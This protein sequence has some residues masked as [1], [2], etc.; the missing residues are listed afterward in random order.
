MGT[1]YTRKR[2][3]FINW[4][5][6]NNALIP[7]DSDLGELINSDRTILGM[8]FNHIINDNLSISIIPSV[9]ISYWSDQTESSNK[10]SSKLYRSE[11]RANYK[12][13]ARTNIISGAEFQ[14]N[15][16]TSNIFGNR[17]A[18]IVGLFSQMDYKI[19]APLNLSFGIRYDNSNLTDL[20]NENSVSPKF[21]INYKLDDDTYLRASL[22][23][24]FRSPSL[25]EAFTSTT[26]SG[27]TV[28]P[29]PNL[30]SE[31]SYSYEAGINHNF[32]DIV[33]IDFAVFNNEYFDMIEIEFDPFNGEAFFNNLTRAR[34]QGF[35]LSTVTNLFAQNLSFNLSYTYLWARDIEEN[36]MLKYRPRHTAIAGINFK[37]DFLEMGIDF[38]FLSRVD[39]IDDELVNLGTV[40]DGDK[41]VDIY[42]LDAR[43]GAH[44][45]KLKIPC[46]LFINVNNLLNYN[47][48]EL[49]GNLAPI[50]NYSLNLE[51][52]F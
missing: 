15:N 9:Y 7:A 11:I 38:R 30:K 2:K 42:V 18:N 6:L 10:S 1:G 50:R 35:D 3:T 48:V 40:P 31:T 34:I 41:R 39:K 47:Y 32:Y 36:V 12:L 13:A 24:G 22:G 45:F 19:I 8:N 51:F 4:K 44:L 27:L 46:R 37:H 52:I 33:S 16:V 28:I 29:N 43:I 23:K 5:D 25:A 20:E 14:Y 26:L 21:G 49:I 17:T